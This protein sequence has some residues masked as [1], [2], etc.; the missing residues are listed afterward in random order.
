METVQKIK[1]ERGIP[2]AARI[3][4]TAK[5][6]L[7]ALDES[8]SKGVRVLISLLHEVRSGRIPPEAVQQG[9][10]PEKDYKQLKG[11]LEDLVRYRDVSKMSSDSSRL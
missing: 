4:M 11:V 5:E 1:I 9:D 6:Y 7:A 2:P 3:S 10:L 8:A